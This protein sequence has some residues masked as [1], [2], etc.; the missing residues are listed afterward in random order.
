VSE[1]TEDR[2]LAGKL[3]VHQPRDGFRAGLDAV[4]LAAAVP[5]RDGETA[6]ELGA[7]VGTACLCLARRVADCAVTGVEID[8][9]TA[10]LA[11]ENVSHNSFADRVTITE[12]DA[13]GPGL[14]GDYDHVFAN[15]PF[16]VD[17]GQSSPN[18]GRER[19][20]RDQTGLASWVEAGLKRTRSHGTLT[21]IFRADRL[22]EVLSAAP[23]TGASVFPLWP[24]QGEPAKRVIVQIVKGSSAP[25][26]MLAGLALHESDGRYTHEADAVLRGESGI[27]LR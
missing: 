3:I 1:T 26:R 4:M 11:R 19:A 22:G 24:R 12:G 27:D 5:A 18:A 10:A 13:L 21:L 6:L 8:P 23:E 17:D 14:R 9:A 20:K 2:F 15:P 7:G 16:H 25:L